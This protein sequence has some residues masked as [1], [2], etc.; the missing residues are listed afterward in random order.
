MAKVEEEGIC[1]IY[2]FE[3]SFFTEK[4]RLYLMQNRVLRR[5]A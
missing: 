5:V 1:D 4:E 3:L 2:G